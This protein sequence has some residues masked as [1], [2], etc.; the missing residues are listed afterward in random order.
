MATNIL[1][2]EPEAIVTKT[3]ITKLQAFLWKIS[4]PR[5]IYHFIYQIITRHLAVTWNLT[6]R[7][8]RCAYNCSQCGD[9]YEYVD[10]A[11]FECPPALQ[12]WSLASTPF[13]PSIFMISSVYT[14]LDYFFWRKSN[15]EERELDTDHP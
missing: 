6:R 9:I 4:A 5:K 13:F 15:I 1:N 10:H 12:T 11:I 3:S 7:H 8:M 2:H 14:N